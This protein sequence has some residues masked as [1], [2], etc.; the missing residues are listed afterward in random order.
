M[1][2]KEDVIKLIKNSKRFCLS[3]WVHLHITGLGVMS[4]CCMSEK[5]PEEFGYGSIN[6]HSFHELWQGE[7][8]RKMRL[9]ILN[10]EPNQFCINCYENRLG[11]YS[12]RYEINEFDDHLDW[13]VNTDENGYAPDAKPIFWDIRFSN[14]CNLKCRSCGDGSSTSW[15]EDAKELDDLDPRNTGVRINGVADSVKLL[16]ELEQYLPQIESIRFAGGEPLLIEENYHILERLIELNKYDVEV[17]FETNLTMLSYKKYKLIPLWNKLNNLLLTISIDGLGSKCEYLRKGLNWD[18]L[19]NNLIE[20]KDKCTKA[21]KRINYTITAYNI[22]HLPDFHREMV[23]KNYIT[24]NEIRLVCAYD[25]RYFSS[26][27]LPKHLKKEITKKYKEHIRWLRNQYPYCNKDLFQDNVHSLFQWFGCIEHMN[28]D[29][30]TFLIP[31]FLQFSNELD[32][33][34]NENCLSVFPELAPV[35]QTEQEWGE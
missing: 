4:P 21:R 31:T 25:P 6:E 17:E 26:K 8:I 13:V 12:S 10:D 1:R 16:S 5:G 23:E 15:Y 30:W 18:V 33:L 2:T 19:I 24:A 14:I 34:R 3:P 29:D 27:I 9:N 32:Q 22:D 7:I 28:H 20:I 35:F 11:H